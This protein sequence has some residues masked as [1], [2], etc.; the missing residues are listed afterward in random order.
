MS[1]N[2]FVKLL[3]GEIIRIKLKDKKNG[4]THKKIRLVLEF[5]FT[6][7]MPI[8]KNIE[9]YNS[10]FDGLTMHNEFQ[11]A[12]KWLEIIEKCKETLKKK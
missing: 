8:N 4:Q 9:F 7:N 3:I 5:T 2:R 11:L 12:E 6:K 1:K 10:E